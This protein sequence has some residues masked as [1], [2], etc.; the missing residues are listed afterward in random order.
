MGV[1]E[2]WMKLSDFVVR[3]AII[4]D[5]KAT[6][7][8]A[9]LAEIVRSL[10]LAGC[11]SEAD[12]EGV[13]RAILDRETLGTTG[14]GRRVACPEARHPAVARVI[15]TIAL[16]RSGVDFDSM[17]GE[18]ADILTLLL[19]T[20]H[21]PADFLMAGQILS[22]HLAD[23]RFCNRLRQARTPEQV[24]TLMEE[25]EPRHDR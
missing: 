6:M 21:K 11:F 9:A 5:L 23:E 1:R 20:P 24:I 17:D 16:S 13:A 25:A 7:K 2:N 4:A 15:G 12:Q 19:C 10:H 8:E 22:R 18:S 14:I 3:E